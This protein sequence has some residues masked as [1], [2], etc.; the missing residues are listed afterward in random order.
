MCSSDLAHAFIRQKLGIDRLGITKPGTDEVSEAVL[1]VDL[2]RPDYARGSEREK[3]DIDP[4]ETATRYWRPVGI[5]K[6]FLDTLSVCTWANT[7][8]LTVTEGYFPNADRYVLYL[9]ISK[10]QEQFTGKGQ[11]LFRQF[12]NFCH[13]PVNCSCNLLIERYR[14]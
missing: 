11:E 1:R 10:L 13:F 12:D 9:S 7:E 4:V 3:Y 2:Q 14:T 5:T 8:K 6:N